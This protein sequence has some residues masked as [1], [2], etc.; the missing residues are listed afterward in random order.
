MR[1]SVTGEIVLDNAMVPE[2][3]LLPNVSGLAGPFGCLN[4]ARYG[5]AWGA[6][7]AAEFCWHA[8]RQYTL[9]RKQ[10]GR[11]LAANQLI[12]K[13]LADMQ[14]EIT[15]GLHGVLAPRPPDRGGP[16]R[17]RRRSR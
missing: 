7:G 11:P 13:K 8:A 16:R 5:I 9:D 1:A 6:M 2:D 15:L 4:N 10:F 3:A 12:Q 14:T 17:R